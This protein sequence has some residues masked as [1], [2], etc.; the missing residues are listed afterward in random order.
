MIDSASIETEMFRLKSSFSREKNELLET[1]KDRNEA[2][3]QFLNRASHVNNLK[4]EQAK[5]V[6]SPRFLEFQQEAKDIYVCLRR[7][8]VCKCTAEHCCG[9]AVSRR[10][11]GG[12]PFEMNLVFRG[13][14]D[15]PKL[16]LRLEDIRPPVINMI[17]SR[18]EKVATLRS[19]IAVKQQKAISQTEYSAKGFLSSF[20]LSAIN[21]EARRSASSK[22]WKLDNPRSILKKGK[23]FFRGRY[24]SVK[25]TVLDSVSA[26][27]PVADDAA[28]A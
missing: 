1:V 15:M 23:S 16:K 8:W 3:F 14:E 12:R 27:E 19:Q 6:E 10:G 18:D 5:P 4:A 21:S 11:I 2:I 17:A 22:E 13:E 25:T 7:H 24:G 20:G 26:P 28:I 9:I